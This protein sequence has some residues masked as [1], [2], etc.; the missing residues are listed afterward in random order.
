MHK[1]VA[2]ILGAAVILAGGC[3]DSGCTARLD[4]YTC[5]DP[6]LGHLDSKGEPDPCHHE[7][8]ACLGECVPL[9]PF[10]GWE[11]PALLWFGPPLEA[12]ECPADRAPILA[13]E[14]NADPADQECPECSCAPPSGECALS[15]TLTAH[16]TLTC[17]GMAQDFSA[18]EPWDGDC[19]D[20]NPV[21]AAFNPKSVRV[22]A[23]TLTES[24][25]APITP[26]PP[27]SGSTAWKTFARAC[28]GVWS[29]CVEPGMICV[30]EPPPPPP[31]FS[32]CIFRAGDELECPPNYPNRHT[33]YS[34]L[35]DQRSCT[36]CAC[37]PP[38]GSQCSSL[39]TVFE[40]PGCP[41]D[42]P[43]GGSVWVNLTPK[44]QQLSDSAALG[45]KSATPA[46]YAPGSCE[47]LGGEVAGTLELK[48]AS[49]FCCQ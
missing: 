35:D 34:D 46:Y 15:S 6:D 41:I 45:S 2:L 17:T 7:E 37:A 31:G 4:L 49:T 1:L 8:D 3:S 44:C 5:P 30:P 9:P 47:P 20:L 43:G 36:E 12:P 32:Q 13:Y 23:L 10:G 14:G 28:R 21:P 18:P 26:P 16:T 42:Q 29:P 22:E 27:R 48:G 33:F 11:L 19:T 25:C 39:V 38:E 40:V 24:A